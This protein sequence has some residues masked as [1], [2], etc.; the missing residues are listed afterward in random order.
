MTPARRGAQ[1]FNGV[2]TARVGQAVASLPQHLPG[3][4]AGRGAEEASPARQ[5]P[6]DGEHRCGPAAIRLLLLQLKGF[7]GI[8]HPGASLA[9]G[10]SSRSCPPPAL[11]G[12]AQ[13]RL[14]T[15]ARRDAL[16]SH[17]PH[18][19]HA[20][21]GVLPAGA[22]LAFLLF[23]LSRSQRL[24]RWA[25][26]PA[27]PRLPALPVPR[28]FVKIPEDSG[29]LFPPREPPRPRRCPASG[30]RRRLPLRRSPRSRAVGQEAPPAAPPPC[31]CSATTGAAASASTP[32]PTRRVRAAGRGGG[33]G[34]GARGASL[35]AHTPPPAFRL[36]EVEGYEG[37]AGRAWGAIW[38]AQG[39]RHV[40]RPPRL[41]EPRR[42]AELSHGRLGTV[43][44]EGQ[45]KPGPAGVCVR[46]S[47]LRPSVTARCWSRLASPRGNSCFHVVLSAALGVEGWS[48]VVKR[49]RRLLGCGLRGSWT[50]KPARAGS[51]PFR[52]EVRDWRWARLK[53]LLW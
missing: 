4:A 34:R 33:G 19:A 5:G 28:S 52:A 42:G 37:S 44:T 11:P 2:S 18:R 27:Q 46:S 16:A 23:L 1:P 12:P 3:P 29:R 8:L 32:K 49:C 7:P 10:V 36:G 35:I 24:P 40:L 17:P 26:A 9:V 20:P 31:R 39:A 45:G 6:G 41:L 51:C 15:R 13:P 48:G 50:A 14:T 25:A 21:R 43:S 53:V 30:R 47:R 22:F 38:G